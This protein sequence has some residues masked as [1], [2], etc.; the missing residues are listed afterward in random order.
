MN[1][2]RYLHHEPAASQ[3]EVLRESRITRQVSFIVR[4]IVSCPT[5]WPPMMNTS[6]TEHTRKLAHCPLI[7]QE[8]A[9]WPINEFTSILSTDNIYQLYNTFICLHSIGNLFYHDINIS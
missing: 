9:R 8:F 3:H 2:F 5:Q 6:T 7:G 4:A 1:P